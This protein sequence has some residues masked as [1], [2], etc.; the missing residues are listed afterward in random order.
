[1]PIKWILAFAA[2]VLLGYAKLS[3]QEMPQEIRQTLQKHAIGDWIDTETIDGKDSVTLVRRSWTMDQKSL[4]I[5]AVGEQY[6]YHEIGY[7]DG[8]AFVFHGLSTDGGTWH[9]TYDHV[10]G[11]T[12][13][14]HG[15]GTYLGK[16]WDEDVSLTWKADGFQ[17]KTQ[18]GGKP[19]VVNGT[20][21]Y[22]KSSAD[23]AKAFGEFMVGGVWTTTDPEGNLKKHAYGWLYDR[24]FFSLAP[25]VDSEQQ[26]S[27]HGVD[28]IS[29]FYRLWGFGSGG[30]VQAAG[31]QLNKNTW[32]YV[33][34][35][36]TEEGLMQG[37]W[38]LEATDESTLTI[39]VSAT[40][41]G[42]P[43]EYRESVWHRIEQ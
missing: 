16:A 22:A 31:M 27:M 3:A 33:A 13:T 29:G 15:T 40:L 7:W 19:Y 43:Q 32:I 4:V 26:T 37:T 12:W 6:T 38:K 20:R 36:Q 14:G 21:Q 1:M 17:Y 18:A 34:Q 30:F 25:L 35:V 39:R 5:E 24:K 11:D 41:D 9:I 2:L 10:E 42:E 28:P 23:A 8:K